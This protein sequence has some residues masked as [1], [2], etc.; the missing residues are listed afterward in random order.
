MDLKWT[1]ETGR[2]QRRKRSRRWERFILKHNGSE[3]H[4]AAGDDDDY[5]YGDGDGG[6]G[7]GGDGGGGGGGDDDDDVYTTMIL[8]SEAYTFRFSSLADS[9]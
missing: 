3:L 4:L 1:E 6:G 9:Q 8:N 7:G 5:Y 2:L